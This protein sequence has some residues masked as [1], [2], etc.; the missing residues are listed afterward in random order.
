[1]A[2][3]VEVGDDLD[4]GLCGVPNGIDTRAASKTSTRSGSQMAAP[5]W[6]KYGVPG[7]PRTQNSPG[8]Q[9]AAR[10]GLALG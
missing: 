1:L 2:L 8:G 9:L 7:T 10:Y 3:F 4:Y 6:D 5:Y